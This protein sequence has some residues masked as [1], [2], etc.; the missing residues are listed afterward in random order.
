MPPQPEPPG[1]PPTNHVGLICGLAIGLPLGIAALVAVF[2]GY[3]GR[4]PDDPGCCTLEAMRR[5]YWEG[6]GGGK[7]LADPLADPLLSAES[8]AP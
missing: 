3:P 2:M 7:T 8:S 6:I 5:V 1:Y 4:S